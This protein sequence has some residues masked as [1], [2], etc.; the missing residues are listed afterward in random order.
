MN[1]RGMTTTWNDQRLVLQHTKR[2]SFLDCTTTYKTQ[3]IPRSLV[4]STRERKSAPVNRLTLS[5]TNSRNVVP[6]T[7]HTTR[8]VS[9][10]SRKR[11]STPIRIAVARS[12]LFALV[13]RRNTLHTVTHKSHLACY[14]F[15]SSKERNGELHAV[16]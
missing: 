7:R 10:L 1:D 14:G 5:P 12:W 4:E 16:R 8:T 13:H 3:V 15:D 11:T 9:V 2:W 6:G